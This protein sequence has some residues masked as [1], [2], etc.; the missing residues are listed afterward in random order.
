MVPSERRWKWVRKD[1]YPEELQE[2][3]EKLSEVKQKKKPRE[4]R[5]GRREEGQATQADAGDDEEEY[6]TKVA[7]RTDLLLDYSIEYNVRERLEALT[8]ERSKG[9][10]S[11]NFHV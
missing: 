8:L 2:L 10:Y 9:K 4:G 6:V 5:A 11:A 7:T 3:I 1:C